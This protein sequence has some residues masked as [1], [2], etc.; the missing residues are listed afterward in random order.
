[1]RVALEREQQRTHE[2]EA[3]SKRIQA[4]MENMADDLKDNGKE[5]QR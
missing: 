3:R 1:M 4:L 2:N 5:L